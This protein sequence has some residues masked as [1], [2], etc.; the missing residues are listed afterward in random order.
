MKFK[1]KRHLAGFLIFAMILTS[2]T[3]CGAGK[4]KDDD[5]SGGKTEG[6]L[7]TP[8]EVKTLEVLK[9]G[10]E[11]IYM[12]TILIYLIMEYKQVNVTEDNLKALP[13]TLKPQA[14]NSLCE[15]Y[16]IYKAAMDS[17]LTY[18][19]EDEATAKTYADAFI[20]SCRT[21]L[22]KCG[23]SDEKV[24]EEYR[25]QMVVE[26]F[27]HDEKN[28]I[29]QEKTAEYKKQYD[30]VRFFRACSIIF[31][32]V[33]VNAENNPVTNSDGS[34]ATVT[35]AEKKTAYENAVKARDEIIAGADYKEVLAKYEVEP[36]SSEA[37]SY[38]GFSKENGG[39]D[40]L[41]K[42][43]NGEA[44][45]IKETDLG[46]S[47]FVMTNEDDPEL[48]E[49][50]I[51]YLV[52]NDVDVAYDYEE[53]KWRKT[54]SLDEKNDLIGTAWNDIDMTA[55]GRAMMTTGTSGNNGEN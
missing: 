14:L 16:A 38:E 54:L 22:D 9:L 45:E 21:V 25:K 49:Y 4:K 28:R 34:Y 37:T 30:N 51:E 2:L 33:K 18:S 3:A 36:Y 41:E 32:T 8:D 53:N 26:K 47:F 1:L 55:F 48:R 39:D 15:T 11:T 31:P 6:A 24:Y 35:D 23:I 29:G 17:G 19:E 50:Y 12:D 7:Y 20:E 40:S 46:Y 42:L 27:K 10:D 44:T 5:S 13:D 52:N 43:K